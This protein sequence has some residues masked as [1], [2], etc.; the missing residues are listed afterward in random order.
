[1]I[2]F[3]KDL[4]SINEKRNQGM[5]ERGID[6]NVALRSYEKIGYFS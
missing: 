2:N 3:I 5:I 4:E 6:H 1:M